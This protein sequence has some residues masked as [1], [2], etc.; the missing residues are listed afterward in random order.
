MIGA[1]KTKMLTYYVAF[2]LKHAASIASGLCFNGYDDRSKH[3]D[4]ILYIERAKFNRVET[5]RLYDIEF[6]YK[7]KDFFD[8][9]NIS[10]HMWLKYYVFL[11]MV[12]RDQRNSL[13]PI[14]A[15]FVVSAVWHGFYPGYFMFFISSGL[16]DY[17]FKQG[18]KIYILFE[19]MPVFIKR[20]ILL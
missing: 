8:A 5:I 13:T 2:C 12:K 7:V 3:D 20:F 19:W 4:V 15:T 16:N 10:V 1:L 18:E 14:L 9:W 6:S 11:R 17:M